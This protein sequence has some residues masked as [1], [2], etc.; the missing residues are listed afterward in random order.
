MAT[1]AGFE[2]ATYGLAS[3]YSFRCRIKRLWSGLSLHHWIVSFRC[4]P[5]SLYTFP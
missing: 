2:P 1:P 5:S 4:P 3:H